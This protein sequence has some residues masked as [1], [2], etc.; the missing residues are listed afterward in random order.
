M[1]RVFVVTILFIIPSSVGAVS[2][3]STQPIGES[4]LLTID[5]IHEHTFFW[6][7]M[8]ASV[9][10]WV[11]G[12]T[13]GFSTSSDWLEK[14]WASPPIYAVLLLDALIFVVVGA[15]VGTGIYNP[16]TFVAALAAGITWPIGLGALTTKVGT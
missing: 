11:L 4:G 14:Y 10:G 7:V 13:K 6:T 16:A 1:V 9:V 15:Y 5:N 2:T 12:M 8:A 3:R